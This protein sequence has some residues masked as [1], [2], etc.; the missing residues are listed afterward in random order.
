MLKTKLFDTHAHYDDKAYGK[1]SAGLIKRILDENVAGFIQIGCRLKEIPR[2][3]E[4]ASTHANVY[5]AIGIHPHYVNDFAKLPHDYLAQLEVFAASSEKVKAIGEM[6][7]DYHYDGYNRE[8]QIKA[9]REQL[10]LAEKLGLPAIIHSREADEDALA[11]LEEF[12]KNF[13]GGDF[14]VVVHCYSGG[15]E[16]SRRLLEMGIMLSFTGVLTFKNAKNAVEVCRET[17]LDMLMLE[18]DCPYMAP[19]PFRGKVCDSSMAWYT[20]EKIAEIKGI[21]A[22]EVVTACN[23]NA[24]KFFAIDF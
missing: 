10:R 6:G 24:R 13:K 19:E 5:A 21:S 12:R 17:P 23:D 18:T 2:T 1:D 9:F 22:A 15:L 7:L 11:I 4:I 20:A 8:N 16:M 14:K 3:L